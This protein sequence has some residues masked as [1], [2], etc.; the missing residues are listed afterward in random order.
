MAQVRACLRV[1]LLIAIAAAVLPAC[2]K[3]AEL[4]AVPGAKVVVPFS[5]VMLFR[6]MPVSTSEFDSDARRWKDPSSPRFDEG[7]LRSHPGADG[8][9]VY[10]EIPPMM[11]FR[12]RGTDCGSQNDRRI[13]ALPWDQAVLTLCGKPLDGHIEIRNDKLGEAGLFV[14]RVIVPGHPTE[15]GGYAYA[16][17]DCTKGQRIALREVS[18]DDLTFRVGDYALVADPGATYDRTLCDRVAKMREKP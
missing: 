15:D 1:G 9:T 2:R 6:E 3:G 16:E 4:P 11:A 10:V 14:C 13:C 8:G 17:R 18:P 5:A 7:T 12:N